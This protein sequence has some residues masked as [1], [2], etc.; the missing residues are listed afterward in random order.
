MSSQPKAFLTPEQYLEIERKAER[1]SEYYRGEMF[2]MSG[3]RVAHARLSTNIVVALMPQLRARGCEAFTSD[4]RV[5]AGDSVLYTYPDVTVICGE[6]K[7]L[8]QHLDTLLNPVLLVEVLS[9]STEAYDRG[10][11]F[12]LYQKIDSLRYYMLVSQDQTHID[13]FYKENDRWVLTS[14]D[15]PDSA[16]EVPGLGCRL[17]LAEIYR[18][19]PPPEHPATPPPEI[20]R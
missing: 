17:E 12:Q 11:K 1:K 15:G 13:L 19:V 10:L 3:V 14:A 7:L 4:L 16:I 20:T 2:A 6:P 5:R 18:N 9:P 8:D